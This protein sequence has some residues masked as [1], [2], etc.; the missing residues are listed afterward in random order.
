MPQVSRRVLEEAAEKAVRRTAGRGALGNAKEGDVALIVTPPDQDPEVLEVVRSAM[1]DRGVEEVI[2]VVTEQEVTGIALDQF[3]PQTAAEG[4]REILWRE[5]NA[6]LLGYDFSLVRNTLEER[7]RRTLREWLERTGRRYT[8]IYIGSAGRDYYRH[9][10]GEYK[11]MFRDNWIY[12]TREDLLSEATSFP[13]A[14]IQLVEKKIIDLLPDIEEVRISDLEGS[15]LTFS[16]TEDEARYWASGAHLTGHLFMY[17][18]ADRHVLAGGAAFDTK[19]RVR[20]L[21]PKGNG[22]AMGCSNHFGFFPRVK[23]Y[24]RDGVV[25]RIEGG[26]Q[27]GQ[28]MAELEAKTRHVHYPGFPRP[29]YLYLMEVALGT[30]PKMGMR[31]SNL[32]H[33]YLRFPNVWER[34]QAGVFHWGFGAES[35]NEDFKRYAQENG[36]PSMHGFHVHT[37]FNTYEAKLRSSKRW[38][39]VIDRGRLTVLDDEDV[40]KLAAQHGNPDELLRDSWRPRIPGVNYPGDYQRDY[41]SNPVPW[42][43]QELNGLLPTTVGVNP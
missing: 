22:V 43:W 25:E 18:G 4:W 35:P 3:Q 24:V 14:I 19:D 21:F 10:L 37:Y 26:G 38:V 5:E 8:A 32:F 23:I 36:L 28:L 15:H 33:T 2:D 17:P 39:K 34:N 12:V 1:R 42:V 40:R 27:F 16:V 20:H 41:A 13:D 30:H 31:K 7:A 11:H 6:R 29:G 9:F